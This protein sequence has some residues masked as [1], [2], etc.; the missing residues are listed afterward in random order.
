MQQNEWPYEFVQE[1]TAPAAGFGDDA[2]LS[3]P[4]I[5][6]LFFDGW[7]S[8]LTDGIGL[9]PSV[10]TADA[11]PS[12]RE[13]TVQL[14]REIRS[15]D[16]LRLGVRAVSRRRRSFTLELALR[17]GADDF[18]AATCRTVQVCVGAG[19]AAEVPAALWS[20]VERLE[21]RLI[22]PEPAG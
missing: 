14:L 8:Y 11:V 9:G 13:L 4:E 12:T 16:G 21:G 20:A 18:D 15:G 17:K 22:P 1:L 10:F 3:A 19:G 5:T 2:H 6:Q 7:M